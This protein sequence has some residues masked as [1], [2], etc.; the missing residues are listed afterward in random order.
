[1]RELNESK[2]RSPGHSRKNGGCDFLA[3]G[4]HWRKRDTE[5]LEYRK[6][7]RSIGWMDAVF[8]AM[9]PAPRFCVMR[10]VLP[11]SEEADSSGKWQ[12]RRSAFLKERRCA[13]ESMR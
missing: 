4:F 8:S 10:S 13:P 9:H 3:R 1:L 7:K 11:S 12:W 5:T 2:M 6:E